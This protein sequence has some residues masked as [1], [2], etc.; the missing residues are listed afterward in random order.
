MRADV[1]VSKK[2]TIE[3]IVTYVDGHITIRKSVHDHR[4][5]EVL[6][7]VINFSGNVAV[8]NFDSDV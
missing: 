4:K 2:L 6:Y 1:R 3:N 7:F 5:I 8:T